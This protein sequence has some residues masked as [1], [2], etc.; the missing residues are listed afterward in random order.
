MSSERTRS[1]AS[2]GVGN[3]YPALPTWA[4]HALELG[5]WRTDEELSDRCAAIRRRLEGAPALGAPG[6]SYVVP[7]LDEEKLL[8]ATLATLAAQPGEGIERIVVDNGSS[9]RSRAIAEASGFTLVVEPRRGIARA[10]QAGLEASRGAI[11]ASA[12]ADA[13]YPPTHA[14]VVRTAYRENEALAATG[15]ELVYV[16]TEPRAVRYRRLVDRMMGRRLRHDGVDPFP[17]LRVAVGSNSTYRRQ[18]VITSGGYRT[19][20]VCEEDLEL[21]ARMG[22]YGSVAHLGSEARVYASARR[23]EARSLSSLV[24]G[25]AWWL[26]RKRLRKV[27]ALGHER[28]LD[29]KRVQELRTRAY[30]PIR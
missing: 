23:E 28:F 30:P 22:L 11:L 12:D 4:R 20:F 5:R 9:D 17:I 7:V 15:G 29:P 2:G 16:F 21:F 18:L 26:L 14:S 19:D 1:T 10:R 24:L 27:P 13:L 6:I 8:V 3:V 25:H